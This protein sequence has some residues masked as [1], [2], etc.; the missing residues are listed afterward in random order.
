MSSKRLREKFK[1][2]VWIQGYDMEFEGPSPMSMDHAH[3]TKLCVQGMQDF[4]PRESK[5]CRPSLFSVR[6]RQ[7]LNLVWTTVRPDGAGEE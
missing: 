2:M 5:R 7:V 4:D 3:I 6:N 1:M